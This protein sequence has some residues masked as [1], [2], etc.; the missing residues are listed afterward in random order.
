MISNLGTL[1][2]GACVPLAVTAQAQLSITIGMAM[3]E[4]QAKLAGYAG[5]IAALTI[6]PGSIALAAKIAAAAQ[7]AGSLAAAAAVG[8]PGV[9]LQAAALL[10]IVAEIEASIGALNLGLEFVGSMSSL[11]AAAGVSAHVYSGR[12]DAF[13]S[14]FQAAFAGGLPSGGGPAAA[15]NALVLAT[16]SAATWSAM[17]GVFRVS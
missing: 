17:G 12:A 10:A 14:E 4:L 6:T 15:T 5:V 8:L 13:G 9:S 2:V 16:T 11:L 1:S 3:P 7:V